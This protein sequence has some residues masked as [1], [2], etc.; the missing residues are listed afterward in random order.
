MQ[1]TLFDAHWQPVAERILFVNNDD[2]HFLPSI[3]LDTLGKTKRGKNVLSINVPDSIESNLSIS[4]T[5]AGLGVD[6]SDDIV[7]R[8]LLTGELKGRVYHPGF[9]FS[10][11]SDSVAR[12]LDLVMLTNGWRRYKWNDV[13]KGVAPNI[14]Y[15]NDTAWLN[16]SGQLYGATPKQIKNISSVLAIV[17]QKGNDSV[18]QYFTLPLSGTGSFSKP[19]FVF[20]DTLKVYYQL[21]SKSGSEVT[22]SAEVKF[23]D[24]GIS[25]LAN[26]QL[27]KN[28]F[29]YKNV[30]TTGNY[31]AGTL[32]TEEARLQ[33]LLKNTTLK[34]VSVKTRVKS[35][36]QLMDE[37]YAGGMFGGG[38]AKQFDV[39]NDPLAASSA[40]VYNY[41]AGRVAGLIITK[42]DLGRVSVTFRGSPVGMYV[43]EVLWDPTAV[44]TLNV[45][46]IA[47][48]KVL[49]PPFFGGSG[50]SGQGGAIAIYTRRGGEES[51]YPGSN[52]LQYKLVAGYT[53]VKEFYS[54]DY[55][56]TNQP[57]AQEDAR[58]TLY[59]NP[60]IITTP[61]NHVVK[62]S[63]Y[64]SDVTQKFRVVLEGVSADGKL[65][66]IEKLV[67]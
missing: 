49:R 20:F 58:S 34:G 65:A 43:D 50:G 62:L 63:F 30:D 38:D 26:I 67:Q 2:Y 40:D 27:N 61:K 37:K 51:N 60:L 11:N 31:R 7:S 6:S 17:S 4:V 57:N 28:N 10:N 33:E 55:S 52:G 8:L 64:N 36:M 46:N 5:D 25:P 29:A 14:K 66:R 44:S 24:G 16:F 56:D 39:L 42:F 9:Y 22:S 23:N 48:I 53:N 59:W 15:P 13:V 12:L 21:L 35:K 18:R 47:Y 41:L 19:G 3:S 32:A 45:N 1:V 54:P